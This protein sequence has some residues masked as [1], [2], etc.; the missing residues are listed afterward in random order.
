MITQQNLDFVYSPFYRKKVEELEIYE[1][2]DVWLFGKIYR[3][4]IIAEHN[5]TFPSAFYG[6]DQGFNFHY[7]NTISSLERLPYITYLWQENSTSLTATNPAEHGYLLYPKLCEV[8]TIIFNKLF[9]DQTVKLSQL[10]IAIPRKIIVLYI[11]YNRYYTIADPR[12]NLKEIHEKLHSMY[13]KALS[14]HWLDITQED[15]MKE[16]GKYGGLGNTM[17]QIGFMNFLNI[18]TKGDIYQ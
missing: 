12:Y 6:E 8:Y 9:N 1:D 13:I 15:W 10:K 18:I 7:I 3:T 17:P 11:E 4:Q 14:K 2:L 16:W 5:I